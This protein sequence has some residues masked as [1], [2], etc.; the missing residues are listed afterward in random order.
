MTLEKSLRKSERPHRRSPHRSAQPAPPTFAP[1]E[2]PQEFPP[3]S[4]FQR[5]S[6]PLRRRHSASPSRGNRD[7]TE[8][9]SSHSP[10]PPPGLCAP[11]DGN[12]RRRRGARGPQQ[13]PGDN[14]PCCATAKM[15]TSSTHRLPLHP[16]GR[17][18][19]RRAGAG[20]GKCPLPDQAPP[21][22]EA[23]ARAA[24]PERPVLPRD[25]CGPRGNPR[26]GFS[27]SLRASPPSPN[28]RAI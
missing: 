18:R 15:P 3:A 16:R 6:P 19:G 7:E 17:R 27:S 25:P 20:Q 24:R 12:S 28:L 4:P 8:G 5:D 11:T 14:E 10:C 21:G 9:E 22:Q 2:T 26:K 13:L 1:R 23:E